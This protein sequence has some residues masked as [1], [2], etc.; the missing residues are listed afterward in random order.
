MILKYMLSIMSFALYCCWFACVSNITLLRISETRV[1][2]T[3]PP[4][5]PYLYWMVWRQYSRCSYMILGCDFL[6]MYPGLTCA[7]SKKKKLSA[8]FHVFPNWCSWFVCHANVVAFVC[9]A[10]FDGHVHD[11]RFC[12]LEHITDTWTLPFFIFSCG[13]VLM[14]LRN[15]DKH[16]TFWLILLSPLPRIVFRHAKF[17]GTNIRFQILC[18]WTCSWHFL[19][20]HFHVL[21]SWCLWEIVI[22]ISLFELFH[23]ILDYE[24]LR[25]YSMCYKFGVCHVLYHSFL[26]SFMVLWGHAVEKCY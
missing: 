9:H 16:L 14:F 20:T 8:H 24:F 5:P 4:P 21:P 11:A 23:K 6:N 3:P 7:H 13:S 15:R 2:L 10:N 22:H 18:L 17:D 25:Y 1:I 19:S 26:V 12:D